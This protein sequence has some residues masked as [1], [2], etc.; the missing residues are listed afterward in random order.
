MFQ[1]RRFPPY[2]YVF[3]IR[4]IPLPVLRFP[5]SE[6]HGSQPIRGSPWLIAAY[7]VLLRLPVTRHSPCA[8]S[9]LTF[10]ICSASFWQTPQKKDFDLSLFRGAELRSVRSLCFCY[11]RFPRPTYQSTPAARKQRFFP[12]NLCERWICPN[13]SYSL[14][15]FTWIIWV[16]SV[17]V[18]TEISFSY[19]LYFIT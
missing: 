13:Y 12:R 17:I 19:L 10:H 18:V 3:I 4:S 9:S 15:C 5:H 14:D 16:F 6:I 8:L 2:N 7:H 11:R 1:F